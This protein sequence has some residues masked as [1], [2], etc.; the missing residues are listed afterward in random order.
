MSIL[1]DRNTRVVIQGITGGQGRRVVEQAKSYG[2]SAYL[3]KPFDLDTLVLLVSNT[4]Q[5]RAAAG[6]RRM[7]DSTVLFSKDQP[8]TIEVQNGYSGRT[9]PSRIYDKDDRTLTVFAPEGDD[10][11]VEVPPRALVRIGVPAKDAY[12]SFSTHVLR[13]SEQ[14][15]RV[16]VL[17]KPSVIYRAQR[18]QHTRLALRIPIGYAIGDQDT[19]SE[20]LEFKPGETRDLSLGGACIL[21]AE[22]VEPGAVL[23][24]ELRPKTE[25][26][27]IGAV[28]RVL[29][30]RHSDEP[31]DDGWL[32]GCQF[33]L[34]DPS[35]C[36]L[37]Q[38]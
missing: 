8:I 5:A 27:K 1:V 32:L 14:P 4:S 21:V 24:I 25:A 6:D 3:N 13:S 30:S 2:V 33:I 15:K 31:G 34:A 29:R 26:D 36:R 23:R 17:D 22:E 20:A 19:N 12:Y 9:Y 11:A 38:D 28:A 35:L 16:L 37:L 10:G 18:R 7:S